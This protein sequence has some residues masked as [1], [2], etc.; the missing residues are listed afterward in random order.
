MV[1]IGEN[2]VSLVDEM[3]TDD[4]VSEYGTKFA[5]GWRV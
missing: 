4:K 2:G 1:F 3:S 5:N